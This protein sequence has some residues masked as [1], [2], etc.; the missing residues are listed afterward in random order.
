MNQTATLP[1]T[2]ID[3]IWDTHVVAELSD[4]RALLFIDRIFLHE[5]TGPALLAGLA[6]A[7]RKPAHP[8]LVFGTM[9]HIVDT[10]P[11]RGE[12]TLFAGGRPSSASSASA[13]AK[14][15]CG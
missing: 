4:A 5:R 14:P 2:V 13:R 9:D 1:R 12:R 3:R 8:S 6:A 15:G 11:D 10:F 7:G